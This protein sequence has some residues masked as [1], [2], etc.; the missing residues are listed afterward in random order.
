SDF[1]ISSQARH[2]INMAVKEAVHNVIKHSNAKEVTLRMTLTEDLMEIIVH[3]DGVGF[4]VGDT[5]GNGLANIRERISILGGKGSIESNLNRGTTI[6]I[7]L[8]LM[9]TDKAPEPA[10][11]NDSA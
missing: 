7:S 5:H 9:R 4:V 2:N 6:R 8:G 3:D 10:L 1:Q 11:A